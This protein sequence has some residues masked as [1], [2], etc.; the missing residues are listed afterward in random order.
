[1]GEVIGHVWLNSQDGLVGKW[2]LPSDR[3]ASVG[4]APGNA[5]VIPHSWVP[6]NLCR[7]I[8]SPMG[9]LVQLGPRARLRVVNEFVGDHVFDRYALIALQEGPS[10]LTF[11]ELDELVQLGVVIQSLPLVDPSVEELAWGVPELRDSEEES[12]DLSGTR[13]GARRL[14]LTETQRQRVAATFRHLLVGEAPPANLLAAAAAS[15]DIGEPALT[16]T[17]MQVRDKVN[18][19]RWLKLRSLEQ[20]GHYLCHLSRTITLEDLPRHLAPSWR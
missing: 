15:L 8:P 6:R 1:M 2:R 20:L 12:A 16:K 4:R 19:E 9:W 13:Y 10:T 18:E 11:P 7:F 14:N 3:P 5:L 17:M